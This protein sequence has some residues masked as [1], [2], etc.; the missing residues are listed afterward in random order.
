MDRRNPITE[1]DAPATARPLNIDLMKLVFKIGIVVV[2]LIFILAFF[3]KGD[4]RCDQWRSAVDAHLASSGDDLTKTSVEVQRAQETKLYES[5]VLWNEGVLV[6]K[7][8]GCEPTL[9]G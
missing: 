1:T 9:S 3:T 7:P 4:R 8:P 2:V 6:R 5:G